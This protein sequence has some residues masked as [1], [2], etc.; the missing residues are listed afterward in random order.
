MLEHIPENT[1]VRWEIR[2]PNSETVQ[3]Y[4]TGLTRSKGEK[5]LLANLTTA[6][7]HVLLKLGGAL[8]S[9][10]KRLSGARTPGKTAVA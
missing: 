1:T 4:R 9:A 10:G 5:Q 3:H 7:S 8:T 2:R 6:G